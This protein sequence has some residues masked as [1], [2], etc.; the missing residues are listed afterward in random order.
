MHINCVSFKVLFIYIS[1]LVHSS[2]FLLFYMAWFVFRLIP[3]ILCNIISYKSNT[4]IFLKLNHLLE[5]PMLKKSGLLKILSQVPMSPYFWSFTV[6]TFCIKPFTGPNGLGAFKL[7]QRC[8]GNPLNSV[9]MHGGYSLLNLLSFE[10]IH[11]N[12]HW[13]VKCDVIQW[14]QWVGKKTQ[15][16]DECLSD[17]EYKHWLDTQVMKQITD[18]SYAMKL[19]ICLMWEHRLLF[20]NQRVKNIRKLWM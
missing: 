17:D 8:L 16:Q 10:K 19:E 6:P 9:L 15:F 5:Y 4:H 7:W 3:W 1:F 2:F 13:V 14:A 11:G 20:H 12:K 18:L